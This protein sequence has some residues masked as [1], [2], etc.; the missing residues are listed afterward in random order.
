MNILL[1]NHYAGSPEY[2]MEYRPYYLAREWVSMGHNV[3]IVG[4]NFSHLRIKQPKVKAE[5]IDGIRY[6][7]LETPTYQGNGIGRIKNMLSFLWK[8]Y[9]REKQINAGHKP[10]VVIASSTYPLDTYPAHHI[11][12]KYK[13]KL[14]FEVH[15]IWPLTPMEIGHMSKY[16]PFIMVMQMAENYMCRHVDKLISLVPKAEGHYLEHGLAKGKFVHIPNGVVV[17][18]NSHGRGKLPAD[19]IAL[20]NE[21]R[22]KEKFILGYAGG[23]AKSNALTALVEAASMVQD[24][25]ME[26]V[27]VGK[28]AEK[29][30]LLSLVKKYGLKQV[31]FLPPV[32]KDL[33]P[34]LLAQMDALYIGCQETKLYQYGVSANKIF[35]YM[36]AEKPI[37]WAGNTGNNPVMEAQA[38]I[39][40]PGQPADIAGA[41]R[42][43]VAEDSRHLAQWGRNGSVYVKDK[44]NYR[45]LAEKFI[46]AIS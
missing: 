31:H 17:D 40:V 4:A 15:D 36:L 8:L 46:H 7:W 23:M 25:P 5:C 14:V 32:S 30:H 21:W 42:K 24:L 45:N 9:S 33:V 20:F 13:A 35:D 16:H 37:L 26:M 39:A 11:A 28:G 27:L 38:G 19:Y 44:H 22:S 6:I 1:I 43:M 10:D 41:I 12:K 18:K 2:G 29:T 3:T 34:D